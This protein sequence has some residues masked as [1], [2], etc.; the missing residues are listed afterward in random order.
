M[1]KKIFLSLAIT[2]FS[3]NLLFAQEKMN[4]IFK[5]HYWGFLF[6]DDNHGAALSYAFPLKK[7]KMTIGVWAG[8]FAGRFGEDVGN[9]SRQYQRW[10]FSPE[11]RYHLKEILN[12]WHI[13]GSFNFG[14]VRPSDYP[15]P[16]LGKVIPRRTWQSY[17]ATTFGAGYDY[18]MGISVVG[19]TGGL[20]YFFANHGT[21]TNL[22]PF[23]NLY[24]GFY[25]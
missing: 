25:F 12:G 4:H 24:L 15:M 8:M 5:L 9:A 20:Q 19:F 3:F 14:Q 1:S 11:I 18:K 16:F 17:T 10:Q 22:A 21:L 7:Q 13:Y 6:T 2:F 23:F